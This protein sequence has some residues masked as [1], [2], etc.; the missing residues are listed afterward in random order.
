MKRISIICVRKSC[1]T[2][3]T[4]SMD[5]NVLSHKEK[6]LHRVLIQSMQSCCFI[7][8]HVIMHFC[9]YSY[10]VRQSNTPQ[11]A[12]GASNLQR[13][14]AAGYLTLAA[15]AKYSCEHGTWLIARGNEPYCYHTTTH[16]FY[17]F[18]TVRLPFLLCHGNIPR[19]IDAA[20]RSM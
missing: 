3:M 11:Q 15:F 18:C 1:G 19:H 14:R 8:Q 5:D 9:L 16:R 20:G 13:S 4:P 17:G 2:S 10:L 6:R 7:C 12:D